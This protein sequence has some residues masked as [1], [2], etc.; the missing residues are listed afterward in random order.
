MQTFAAILIGTG[1]VH[2][3]ILHQCLGVSA[4]IAT[5][6]RV[7]ASVR[8][9][10][11]AAL[12]LWLTALAGWLLKT[13][14][15]QPFGLDY[16]QVPVFTLLAAASGQIVAPWIDRDGLLLSRAGALR[17]LLVVNSAVL[18]VTLDAARGAHHFASALVGATGAA[19][20]FALVTVLFAGLRERLEGAAVPTPLRGAAIQMITAGL[21]ALAFL[22]F[23]GQV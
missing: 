18:G 6:H 15:L 11:G 8:L 3:V 4:L 10:A 13:Q 17:A 2:N 14:V 1:L 23:A 12:A 21:M 22:G 5:A 16:L 7:D 9:A 20:G 19:L